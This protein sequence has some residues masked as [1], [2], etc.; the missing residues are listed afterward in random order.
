MLKNSLLD[1]FAMYTNSIY[2]SDLP[3]QAREKLSET[4]IERINAY[5]YS[6][7]EWNEAV[8]YMT[9]CWDVFDSREQAKKYLLNFC[10]K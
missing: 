1:L 8:N 5:D 7:Y 3:K 6:L 9:R 4:V 2:I 10:K